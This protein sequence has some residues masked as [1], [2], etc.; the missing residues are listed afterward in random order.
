MRC[1]T[2]KSVST[3]R[4]VGAE[5]EVLEPQVAVDDAGL[6]QG[7]ERDAGLRQTV[8]RNADGQGATQRVCQGPA[9][10]M[11]QRHERQLVGLPDLVHA[12]DVALFDFLQLPV[13]VEVRLDEG[14]RRG[15]QANDL[16]ELFA[17]RLQMRGQVGIR[18][19]TS[20]W[21][22]ARCAVRGR[23]AVLRQRAV[24]L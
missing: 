16:D 1:V 6:V 14:G 2:L 12:G 19:R 10:D 23:S 17:P 21:H 3:K 9:A 8:E 5:R 15:R 18:R 4:S 13:L 7:I 22:G 11:F 24:R 20:A